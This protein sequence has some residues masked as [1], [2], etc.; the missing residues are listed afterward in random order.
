MNVNK[1]FLFSAA[2]TLAALQSS[3][4]AGEI[5]GVTW[6]SGVA[7]VAGTG[8]PPPVAPNNDDVGVGGS[9]NVIVVTQKDPSI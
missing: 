5:T 9:P 3:V 1:S 7:S 6:F 2:V 8:T 4:E